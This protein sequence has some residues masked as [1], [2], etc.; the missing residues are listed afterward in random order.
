MR[1]KTNLEIEKRETAPQLFIFEQKNG[2]HFN[3][4]ITSPAYGSVLVFIQTTKYQ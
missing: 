1:K 4:R 2:W 3:T